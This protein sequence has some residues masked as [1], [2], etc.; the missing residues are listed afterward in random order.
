MVIKFF[1]I[2]KKNLKK[3]KIGEKG[4]ISFKYIISTELN[5][6]LFMFYIDNKRNFTDSGI[7]P[8]EQTYSTALSPGFHSL[9]WEYRKDISVSKF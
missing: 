2:K 1:I 5:Y 8:E 4:L 7:N 6:D 9:R 3:K